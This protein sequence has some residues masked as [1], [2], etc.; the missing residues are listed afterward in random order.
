[1]TVERSAGG[2]RRRRQI[3]D[4]ALQALARDGFEAMTIEGVAEQAGVN[5]T[6]IYRWWPSKSALLGAALLDAPLLELPL[7][8]TGSLRGDL[9]ELV[10][11]LVR[12][13]TG[14]PAGPVARAALGA[15]VGDPAL[16][17]RFRAFFADR[18]VREQA[19]VDRAVARGELPE[20]I[21]TMLLMDLLAGAVWVRGI[22]RGLPLNDD[23]AREAVAA[24][25]D[26]VLP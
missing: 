13:L 4:A 26:G 19:V 17:M 5:K 14:E 21:D 1:M 16:A 24:V 7:P 20:G 10:G 18:L 23:F 25:L 12:L 2:P 6:T 15:A 9:V 8:D 3:F 11:A 22:F